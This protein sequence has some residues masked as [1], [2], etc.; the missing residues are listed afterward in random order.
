[1]ASRYW[2]KLYHEILHDPKMERLTDH[3]FAL[4]MKLFLLAGEVDKDGELP[5]VDDI[6]WTLRREA[7]TILPDLEE[8]AKVGIVHLDNDRWIVSHFAER[9]DNITPAEGMARLRE[10]R[11]KAEYYVPATNTPESA[12]TTEST[13]LEQQPAIPS[14]SQAI[15]LPSEA[16]VNEPLRNLTQIRLEEIRLDSETEKIRSD[17]PRAP[18]TPPPNPQSAPG[19]DISFS[20]I[21]KHTLPPNLPKEPNKDLVY[22]ETAELETAIYQAWA[23]IS[24]FRPDK[25]EKSILDHM[26]RMF[27]YRHVLDVLKTS[28]GYR[29]LMEVDAF[30]RSEC[31]DAR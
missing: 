4:C 16:P 20:N 6:E 9:Q 8:L 31:G 5:K 3:L 18:A 10:R 30:L 21:N 13:P 1:M 19:R 22:G 29:T 14:P 28:C 25:I 26:C 2:I 23:A 12:A 11:H 27:G 24:S 15:N 17:P 7:G